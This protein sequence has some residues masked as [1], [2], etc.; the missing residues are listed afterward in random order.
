MNS[1]TK[2]TDRPAADVM[3]DVT[4]S[5]RELFAS[6]ERVMRNLEELQNRVESATDWQAQLKSHPMLMLGVAFVGGLL[7]SRV[8]TGRD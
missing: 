6:G 2:D 7:L 4:E 1:Y 3:R 5:S 8:F